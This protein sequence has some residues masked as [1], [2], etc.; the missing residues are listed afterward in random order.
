MTRAIAIEPDQ[1]RGISRVAAGSAIMFVLLLAGYTINAMDRQVFPVLLV[2]VQKDLGFTGPQAGLQSTIFALGI[3][4]LGIPAGYLIDRISRKQAVIL[5]TLIFSAC[6]AL[7]TVSSGFWSMTVWRVL[8]G[9]GESLE[10]TALIAIAAV[11]FPARRGMA[12]G[13][14]NICFA[15]GA[16]IGPALGGQILTQ[17][18]QWRIP[19]I[20]FAILGGL[21]AA[22]IALFVKPWLTERRGADTHARVIIGGSETLLNRN[23]VILIVMT[24]L[25][26]LV[27]F[28]FLGLYATFLQTVHH[29][30]PAETGI[31]T[32]I[33]GAGAVLSFFGGHLGDRFSPRLVLGGSFA[34]TGIAGAAIFLG[35]GAFVWQLVFALLF[36][37][38]FSSGAFVMLAGYLVKSV[39]LR[40]TGIASGIFVTSIY[41]PAAFA[42]LLMSSLASALSWTA[43][44]MIQIVLGSAIATGL[45]F[46]LRPNDFST[47]TPA[48]TPEAST[49]R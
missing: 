13:T 26:G 15:V 32:G 17:T 14:I 27:D 19:E 39:N 37:I 41:I 3:G 46:L 7:T 5:G 20:V 18:G 31:V 12:I 35:S 30:T 22:S 6:T 47:V 8:S 16:L 42:G 24:V 25:G 9:V 1:R 48:R 23:T 29:Y 43:A 38:A 40:Y 28:A 36:G 2:S 10:F 44:G 21:S 34:L 49:L 4:V 45:A 33:S 11:A